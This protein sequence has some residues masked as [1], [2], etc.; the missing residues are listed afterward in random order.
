M[1]PYSAV[2]ALPLLLNH[3]SLSLPVNLSNARRD[4]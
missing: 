4:L 1:V 2:Q 3:V